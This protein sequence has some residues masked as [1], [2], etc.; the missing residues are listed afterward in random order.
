GDSYDPA[1]PFG[2]FAT[3][4]VETRDRVRCISAESGVPMSTQW[5]ATPYYYPIQ[6]AQYGL[7][8]YSRMLVNKT[9]QDLIEKG[10]ESAEWK[11]S[12]DSQDSSERV[13]Y[14]DDEK[15]PLVNITTSGELSN[16]GCYVFL[17]QSPL[18]YVISFEWLSIQN[19]SFTVLV[20][21]IETD[22]LV[23][24]NYVA[25]HDSRCVWNDSVSFAGSEQVSFSFSLG[26]PRKDWQSTTRDILV[27]TSR[28]LSSMNTSKKRDGNVILHPGDIKLV[29][30]GFRGAVI[31]KQRIVQS[32]NAHFKFFLTA[33]DWLASN[34]DDEA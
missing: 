10:L 34:Q 4:S 26:K 1:G 15:G 12:P 27:D 17:D 21:I 13:F 28:A 19:A 32:R 18:H 7:Q 8:H 16:A 30:V 25:Q 6:I 31:V 33:A 29:S 3:Y 14:H 24:L 5:N 23:L 22:M 2:H 9:D 20:R 11:G